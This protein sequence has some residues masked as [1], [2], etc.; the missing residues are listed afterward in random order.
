MTSEKQDS[1][2]IDGMLY[3]MKNYYLRMRD[4]SNDGKESGGF[5]AR[6]DNQFLQKRYDVYL[7]GV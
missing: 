7:H 2:R 4:T 5:H 6:F 1:F 3:A